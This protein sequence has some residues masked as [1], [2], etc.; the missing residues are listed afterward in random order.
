MNRDTS[1]GTTPLKNN[2]SLSPRLESAIR[3]VLLKYEGEY[4]ETLLDW[5]YALMLVEPELRH[6]RQLIDVFDHLWQVGTIQLYKRN[7]W[8]YGER[9]ESFFLGAPFT[10]VLRKPQSVAVQAFNTVI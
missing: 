1:F 9:D 5:F 4:E 3:Q 8:P 6:P 10:A 2:D 7:E